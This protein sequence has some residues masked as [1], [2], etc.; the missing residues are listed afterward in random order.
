MFTDI[1]YFF[2]LFADRFE[3]NRSD[4]SGQENDE[5]MSLLP[6]TVRLHMNSMEYCFFFFQFWVYITFIFLNSELQETNSKLRDINSELWDKISQ[7][8]LFYSLIETV[9]SL[10]LFYESL[11]KC[12]IGCLWI[13]YILYLFLLLVRIWKE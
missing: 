6:G 8:P 1:F 3:G 9:L 2:V 10:E 4:G 5:W 12:V 13:F 11:S 7:L